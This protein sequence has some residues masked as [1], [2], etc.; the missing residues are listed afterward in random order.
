MQKNITIDDNPDKKKVT[1]DIGVDINKNKNKLRI[2]TSDGGNVFIE[3]QEKVSVKNS[4]VEVNDSNVLL[5]AVVDDKANYDITL[6]GKNFEIPA[7]LELLDSQI[8]EN[9]LTDQLI[10]FKDI[11]G[12][13][14]F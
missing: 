8:V 4:V 6:S 9:N 7:V 2:Q 5:S 1:Y 12:D 13:F 14:D 11:S 10:Y 3:N